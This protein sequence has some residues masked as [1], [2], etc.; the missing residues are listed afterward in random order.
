MPS[1][2][3]TLIHHS[4]RSQKRFQQIDVTKGLAIV[5]VILLHALEN[6]AL[7]ASYAIYHIWQAVPVF[8]VL[9]GVNLGMNFSGKIPELS[10][11]YTARYFLK[12]AERIVFPL[13][14][15]YGLAVLAGFT[16]LLLYNEQK[17]DFNAY[18]LIGLLPLTGPGNYFVTLILQSILFFPI[19]DYLFQRQPALTV[20]LLV[21]LEVL[22]LLWSSQSAFFMSRDFLYS[23]ALPRYF[24]AIA[25]GL[26]L[27]R[28][29]LQPFR[30]ALFSLLMAV[31]AA[32]C[33]YLYRMV[34][35]DLKLD[36]VLATWQTQCVLT[37][38][39]AA[40]MVW[41]L[42]GAL[43]V[44]SDNK[45]LQFFSVLGKASYH[46]FLIQIVYFG[47]VPEDTRVL[48]DVILALL[49]GYLFYK[50]D[51]TYNLSKGMLSRK[52]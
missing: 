15:V 6:E 42:F 26:V 43:P 47:L 44:N 52:K 29:I 24:S 23:A 36:Y 25:F 7:L 22:F 33:L 41:I 13:L 5:S 17:L 51:T 1:A 37:F 18:L 21:V 40:A 46:I 9:M 28:A 12:K 20:V 19:I 38:G 4:T 8:I 34:Y 31:A 2:D 30:V 11:L 48:Q 3:S 32:G 16:W 27:S 35:A 14:W 45:L 39:Y 10:S 50:T 49:I